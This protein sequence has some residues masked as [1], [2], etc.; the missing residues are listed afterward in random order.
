MS[1]TDASWVSNAGD[2]MNSTGGEY[3]TLAEIAQTELDLG[4]DLNGDGI[5]GP[6]ATASSLTTPSIP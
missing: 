3:A 5:I 6:V 1:Q 2:D 4:V